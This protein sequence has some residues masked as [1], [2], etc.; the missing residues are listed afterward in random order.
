MID[1]ELLSPYIKNNI[2]SLKSLKQS[3]V[4]L[5][6]YIKNNK[7]RIKNRLN[8][9]ILEDTVAIR[10]IKNIALYLSYYYGDTVN[11]TELR[12]NNIVIY[13]SICT[14]GL[15]EKVIKELGFKVVYDS[16]ISQDELV[17][18]LRSIAD[19]NGVIEKL[20]KRLDNKVRYEA[21]KEY[22]T[23]REYL[24]KLGYHLSYRS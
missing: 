21:N 10:G 20:D 17:E 7:Q 8:I 22:L 15:P 3:N 5:Y 11:L 18:E 1:K 12:N 4:P 2:L 23:V 13:N 16:K 19:E 24:E 6:N 9:E 14:L